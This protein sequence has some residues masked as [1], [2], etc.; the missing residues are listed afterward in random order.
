MWSHCPKGRR[1][2]GQPGR[3]VYFSDRGPY[4]SGVFTTP[5]GRFPSRVTKLS[6]LPCV[7]RF[8]RW[9]GSKNIYILFFKIQPSTNRFVF[10]YYAYD[11]A[12]H[13]VYSHSRIGSTI[14]P[15][16]FNHKPPRGS[17]NIYNF[18][19]HFSIDNFCH[20]WYIDFVM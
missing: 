13:C 19:I 15:H 18:F 17:K 11:V 16:P 1:G 6:L 4:F 20:L 14:N 7:L 2:D 9:G 5:V 3:D 10:P 8:H 12:R